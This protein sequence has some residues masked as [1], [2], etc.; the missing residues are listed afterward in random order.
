MVLLGLEVLYLVQDE[1]LVGEVA[2]VEFLQVFVG[3][4][5]AVV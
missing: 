4:D 3:G 2:G 1:G 5:D